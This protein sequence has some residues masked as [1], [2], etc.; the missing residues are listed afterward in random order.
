MRIL[1]V[2]PGT[3]RTGLGIIETEG[4][5]YRLLHTETIVLKDSLTLPEKLQEIYQSL[6]AAIQTYQPEVLALE[7]VF[8]GKDLQAMVKIGEARACA[9]LAASGRGI[10]VVEY[11]PARVKQSVTGNGRASKEQMQRMVKVLLN[12]K[13]EPP[14]D[15]ADALAVAICHLH[16]RKTFHVPIP[17]RKTDGKIADGCRA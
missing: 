6:T 3:R 12:L 7:N 15:S 14:P 4:S 1:G 16:C 8:Y 10:P 9:M 5:R 2:D 13:T 17:D 11:A